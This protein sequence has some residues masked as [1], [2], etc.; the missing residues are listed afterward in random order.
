MIINDPFLLADLLT[1]DTKLQSDY[2]LSLNISQSPS[3]QVLS[4]YFQVSC[5]EV[6]N[7]NHNPISVPQG[8]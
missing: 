5:F 6:R 3:I 8:L 7:S 4:R 1:W 2:N